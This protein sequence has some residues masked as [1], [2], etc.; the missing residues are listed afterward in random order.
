M[1][2][3]LLDSLEICLGSFS[4]IQQLDYE[5]LSFRCQICHEYG[6]LQKHCPRI[7]KVSPS[8][9]SPLSSAS[10]AIREDKGKSSMWRVNRIKM[11]LCRSSRLRVMVRRDHSRT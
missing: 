10:K 6:H 2:N 8:N 7:N 3:P 1:N 9:S 5:S 4:S 11:A